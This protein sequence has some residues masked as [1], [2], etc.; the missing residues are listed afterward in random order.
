MDDDE[1]QYLFHQLHQGFI[2]TI[3][4]PCH[5]PVRIPANIHEPTGLKYITISSIREMYPDMIRLE[6]EGVPIKPNVGFDLSSVHGISQSQVHVDYGDN[7]SMLASKTAQDSGTPNL[8]GLMPSLGNGALR[9]MGSSR[10]G[11]IRSSKDSE[12]QVNDD[13]T[14]I[15]VVSSTVQV[16]GPSNQPHV[17][18][19]MPLVS[20]TQAP[21]KGH[22][23]TTQWID[24][25]PGKSICVVHDCSSLRIP[26]SSHQTSQPVALSLASASTPNLIAPS[27]TSVTE[28]SWRQFQ[29]EMRQLIL[30]QNLIL[31]QEVLK[32]N[33]TIVTC[34][35]N[36]QVT[37]HKS[38]QEAVDRSTNTDLLWPDVQSTRIDQAHLKS[39]SG[40]I[41]GQRARKSA[42]PDNKSIVSCI[43][44]PRMSPYP[45]KD[46]TV[47]SGRS[48]ERSSK[49]VGIDSY[50]PKE[51]SSRSLYTTKVLGT[52]RYV[53]RKYGSCHDKLSTNMMNQR[54]LEDD[55]N[56]FVKDC[57]GTIQSDSLAI[58]ISLQNPEKARSFYRFLSSRG[59][60]GRYLKITLMWDWNRDDMEDLVSA[61]GSSNIRTLCLDC[62]HG[63]GNR[64]SKSR[65]DPLVYLLGIRTLIGLQFIAA[66]EIFRETK[67]K[68]PSRI[69]HLSTLQI[70]LDKDMQTERLIDVIQRATGLQRLVL[71]SL[72]DHYRDYLELIKHAIVHER[73]GKPY[74][75]C[76]RDPKSMEIQFN[77]LGRPVLIVAIGRVAGELQEF[78]L[79]LQGKETDQIHWR[80]IFMSD[81]L[82]PLKSLTVL[83]FKGLKDSSWT[84]FLL[85]MI[86]INRD[87]TDN[88]NERYADSRTLKIQDLQIDCSKLRS[89]GLQNMCDLIFLV[90][91]TLQK[92]K[93]TNLDFPT[94][95][96]KVDALVRSEA[97]SKEE[98]EL[99]PNKGSSN[100]IGWK[101]LFKFLRFS[102]LKSLQIER[103]NLGDADLKVLVWYL[104]GYS[105][106]DQR[107]ELKWLALLNTNVTASGM[108]NLILAS[109]EHRWNIKI[110]IRDDPSLNTIRD[111]QE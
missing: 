17:L 50:I 53:P 15:G 85:K 71:D 42:T 102:A 5:G 8:V 106:R 37:L 70:Q 6:L 20:S 31:R 26:T 89:S 83:R 60:Y 55:L 90:R 98:G 51:C 96:P 108:K 93:L 30:D 74:M 2:A 104:E 13:P 44:S 10:S 27:L 101:H 63:A 103:A 12:T 35:Q 72:P 78:T 52:D 7:R 105:S 86:K 43:K 54:F 97:G 109:D 75:Q 1:S 25:R 69:S 100:T 57:Q 32:M 91:S 40:G 61:I 84:S 95:I 65:N 19:D 110:D 80:P 111:R 16:L 82:N 58:N 81:D 34:L 79:N 29:D 99:T 49:T 46:R 41:E 59:Y 22:D 77:H 21:N 62:N 36:Q 4:G 39:M 92:L 14:K 107:L 11:V 73:Q 76:R 9:D 94:I 64:P 47:Y 24:Y 66:P 67:V 3:G 38:Q 23:E 33:A 68:I 87:R 45:S 56:K 48:R 88:Y 18:E 28:S